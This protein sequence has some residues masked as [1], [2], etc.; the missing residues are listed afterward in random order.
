[1]PALKVL[2]YEGVGG[3]G[4]ADTTYDVAELELVGVRRR[5][6]QGSNLLFADGH[7]KMLTLEQM[8]RKEYWSLTE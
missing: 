5:H 3:Q 6:F 7:V 2:V 4:E 1:M 8:A